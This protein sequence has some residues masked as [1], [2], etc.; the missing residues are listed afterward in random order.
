MREHRP[1]GTW[2]SANRSL[3]I[4]RLYQ[5]RLDY[6]KNLVA[7]DFYNFLFGS[8]FKETIFF[9][10]AASQDLYFVGT[11]G[12]NTAEKLRG[13]RPRL[14]AMADCLEEWTHTGSISAEA[15]RTDVFLSAE[16][17]GWAFHRAASHPDIPTG[18]D[19]WLAVS[20]CFERMPNN[21]VSNFL[22][23]ER[24]RQNA[25]PL[26]AVRFIDRALQDK[27]DS[28]HYEF[29][30]ACCLEEA[31]LYKAAESGFMRLF[32]RANSPGILLKLSTMLLKQ[33]KVDE[34][35][36]L[37]CKGRNLYPENPHVMDPLGV[38]WMKR[39]QNDRA[40]TLFEKVRTS[41][42]TPDWLRQSATTRIDQ[43]RANE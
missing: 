36:K 28:S 43:L 18:E 1:A 32:K 37:L 7:E 2:N 42:E 22:M 5:C 21:A 39:G 24:E 3:I 8:K 23:C 25:R 14:E 20:R 15:L 40:I 10:N 17:L 31:A 26:E 6:Y 34:A 38:I 30:R 29:V 13:V 27:P 19:F 35:E 41:E 4:S 16:T 11:W 33:G 9:T 12:A